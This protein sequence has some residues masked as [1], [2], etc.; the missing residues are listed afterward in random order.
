MSDNRQEA[1]E[2]ERENQRL[3]AALEACVAELSDRVDDEPCSYDHH[4][5][6]QTHDL[7]PKPCGNERAKAAI[8]QARVALGQEADA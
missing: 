1:R 6:C 4:G 7:T 8:A 5:Y 2:V 3:K